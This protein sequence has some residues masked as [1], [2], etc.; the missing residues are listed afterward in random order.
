MLSVEYAVHLYGYLKE[1]RNNPHFS[2]TCFLG[3]LL[4]LVNLPGEISGLVG[5]NVLSTQMDTGHM[6]LTSVVGAVQDSGAIDVTLED[7]AQEDD[8]PSGAQEGYYDN[9]PLRTGEKETP[10]VIG[11]SKDG[12]SIDEMYDGHPSEVEG[13]SC[14]EYQCINKKCHQRT[15]TELSAI[16]SIANAMSHEPELERGF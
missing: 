12:G 16:F 14:N 11:A 4:P 6:E 8:N 7:G 15:Q 1:W 9:P 3:L 10:T 2:F 5:T 13:D